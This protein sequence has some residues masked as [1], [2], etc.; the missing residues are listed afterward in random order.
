MDDCFRTTDTKLL[1][2]T[3]VERSSVSSGFQSEHGKDLIAYLRK[4]F[5]EFGANP[6]KH[7]SNHAEKGRSSLAPAISSEESA[8]LCAS[9]VT[10]SATSGIDRVQVTI[11]SS[12][13]SYSSKFPMTT[14]CQQPASPRRLP[15]FGDST[16]L[17]PSS[18]DE[19]LSMSSKRSIKSNAMVA[20]KQDSMIPTRR[21]RL[22]WLD[23]NKSRQ[24]TRPDTSSIPGAFVDDIPGPKES[25]TKIPL[26]RKQNGAPIRPSPQSKK[27]QVQSDSTVDSQDSLAMLD[28]SQVRTP[29][30]IP[31]HQ[32]RPLS[33]PV[34]QESHCLPHPRGAHHHAPDLSEESQ[35]AVPLAAIARELR[36]SLLNSSVTPPPDRLPLPAAED[37]PQTPSPLSGGP[38]RPGVSSSDRSKNPMP[39]TQNLQ[40]S[41]S[42]L[43]KLI[44]EAT[45]LAQNAARDRR[46]DEL[47]RI[48]SDAAQAINEASSVRDNQ[49]K[50]MDVPLADEGGAV[51]YEYD[52]ISSDEDDS[53]FSVASS[54][55][56]PRPRPIK[57]SVGRPVER[58]PAAPHQQPLQAQSNTT[59]FAYS[60]SRQPENYLPSIGLPGSEPIRK[61]G[62]RS[63]T[64]LPSSPLRVQMHSIA[65]GHEPTVPTRRSSLPKETFGEGAPVNPAGNTGPT[66][67][68]YGSPPTG[69]TGQTTGQN[70]GRDKFNERDY[71]SADDLKGK[72]HITLGDNQKWSIHHHRRQPIAR[73][74]STRRKRFTAAVT[75]LNTAVIGM[76]VG[77]YVSSLS[78]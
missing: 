58:M 63:G 66:E 32:P 34:P 26:G 20:S 56:P 25:E 12:A 38:V 55:S 60:N 30:E 44:D 48:L 47:P 3:T 18:S 54:V 75:C 33:K 70:W 37:S 49:R 45:K 27:V 69:K 5:K 11:T 53:T 15:K 10:T 43:E 50:A 21:S 52:S 67:R 59:D 62:A 2:P 39:S 73:N 64:P 14:R 72:R 16:E 78:I 40:Q 76:L 1:Q 31:L 19:S 8:Q 61:R 74:W 77:I 42:S 23:G 57:R 4:L 35:P 65:G 6:V 9:K 13:C 28:S 29:D 24:S 51:P 17:Q 68:G 22:P 36:Q 7:T 71:L 41:I 46:S